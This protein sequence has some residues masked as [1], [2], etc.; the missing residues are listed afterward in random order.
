MPSLPAP[1]TKQCETPGCTAEQ[2][3]RGRCSRCYHRLRYR[4]KLQPVRPPSNDSLASRFWDKVDRREEDEC[5]EW[6]GSKR[7]PWGYGSLTYKGQRYSA[8]HISWFLHHGE[9]PSEI[10]LWA[11]HKCDNPPCV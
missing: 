2:K 8:T 4:G 3:A 10:G 6:T 5:W 7:Q 1:T 11:L 9:W